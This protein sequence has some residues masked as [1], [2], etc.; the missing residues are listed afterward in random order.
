VEPASS[1]PLIDT[2]LVDAAL[3]QTE[4]EPAR[5]EAAAETIVPTTDAALL[6]VPLAPDVSGGDAILVTPP[7]GGGPTGGPGQPLLPP[8]IMDFTGDFQGDVWRFSGTVLDDKSVTGLTVDF[9][10]LL[11][12][13]TAQ[14]DQFGMFEIFVLLGSHPVGTI[15]AY[16]IDLDGLRSQTVNLTLG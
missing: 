11:A 9:G 15:S 14:V 13:R 16:T 5:M 1:A 8:V 7:S 6:V 4:V 2:Q 10:G 3:A 12:G